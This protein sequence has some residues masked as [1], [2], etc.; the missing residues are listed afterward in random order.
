M[1]VNLP[2]SFN[3]VKADNVGQGSVVRRDHIVA[4][5]SFD[6]DTFSVGA[7]ARIHHGDEN[8]ALGPVADGLNQTVTGFPDVVGGDVMGQ[9]VNVQPGLHRIGNAVHGTD[10]TVHQTEITLKY[11]MVHMSKPPGFIYGSIISGIVRKSMRKLLFSDSVGY[12]RK[13]GR[14]E[15]VCLREWDAALLAKLPV[16]REKT[17]PL[18]AKRKNRRIL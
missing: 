14:E 16:C 8:R 17:L 15:P 11:Q 3:A 12:F 4:A 1:L 9:V 6:H 5:G 10:G 13:R 2:D 18:W 7:N